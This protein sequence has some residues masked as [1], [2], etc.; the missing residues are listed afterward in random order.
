MKIFYFLGLA[1]CLVG[2]ALVTTARPGSKAQKAGS[3]L[4]V[5]GLTLFAGG[6]A[7]MLS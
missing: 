6:F 2:V 3:A 1:V 5:L 7:S 4:Y